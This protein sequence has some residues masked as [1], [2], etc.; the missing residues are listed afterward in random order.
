M[1]IAGSRFTS[2][3]QLPF[4]IW[5]NERWT[6]KNFGGFLR[7]W[8]NCSGDFLPFL[9]NGR[10]LWPLKHIWVERI[11]ISLR[12]WNLWASDPFSAAIR[13]Q[14]S[15]PAPGYTGPAHVSSDHL[16][17]LNCAA[18]RITDSLPKSAAGTK[19]TLSVPFPAHVS[20]HPFLF[21]FVL[22]LCF[23][24]WEA[25]FL[26]VLVLFFSAVSVFRGSGS[27]VWW[28]V[29]DKRVCGN[30]LLN[31]LFFICLFIHLSVESET[32]V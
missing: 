31:N 12:V 3:L 15:P 27:T 23:V 4:A 10:K 30:A 20:F 5:W 14:A 24:L 32:T 13:Y 19:G 29:G 17:L 21:V 7:S 28:F 8:G 18:R 11:S 25:V 2:L 1:W 22:L 9:R 6:K 26:V 16:L